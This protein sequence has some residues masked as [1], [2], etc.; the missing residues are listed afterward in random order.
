MTTNSFVIKPLARKMRA[1][2]CVKAKY[3]GTIHHHVGKA[4]SYLSS[5][6]GETVW[7]GQNVAYDA[8]RNGHARLG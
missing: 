2:V 4:D 1:L 5:F 8:R 7:H 6:L 3:L